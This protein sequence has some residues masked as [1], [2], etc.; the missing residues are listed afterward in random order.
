MFHEIAHVL[1]FR[2]GF[3]GQV[4]TTTPNVE[5]YLTPGGVLEFEAGDAFETLAF[6][7][8]IS[9]FT[10]KESVQDS[11]YGLT[12]QA[13]RMKKRVIPISW[14]ISL[15][16]AAFWVT[17][18]QRLHPFPS[19]P[20]ILAATAVDETFYA[21]ETQYL[22]PDTVSPLSGHSTSPPVAAAANTVA[23]SPTPRRRSLRQQIK[24]LMHIA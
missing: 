3:G 21:G 2:Q 19:T 5:A 1:M 11:V 8:H 13:L 24:N 12:F 9:N 16:G 18:P 6:G 7:G 22:S 20:A 17:A 4:A 15:L 10:P 14:A 23:L